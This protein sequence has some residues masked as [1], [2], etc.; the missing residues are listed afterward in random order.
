MPTWRFRKSALVPTR[1][2]A[3]FFVENPRDFV[4][5]FQTLFAKVIETNDEK[6]TV[7]V[8]T[9]R[10]EVSDGDTS[11]A[12]DL[13]SYYRGNLNSGNSKDGT[14]RIQDFV[15]ECPVFKQPFYYSGG[16]NSEQV[17]ISYG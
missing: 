3:D 15:F 2:L 6:Q 7:T 16:S 8:T 9:R 13:V 10:K 4:Q 12:V 1:H 5:P 17:W 14:V 11:H